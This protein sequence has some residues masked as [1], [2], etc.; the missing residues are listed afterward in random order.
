MKLIEEEARSL[1]GLVGVIYKGQVGP[2]DPRYGAATNNTRLHL[3]KLEE[4]GRVEKTDEGFYMK[5]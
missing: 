1:E 4:E 2:D 5:K 3:K